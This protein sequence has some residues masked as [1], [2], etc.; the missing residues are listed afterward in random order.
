MPPSK[1]KILLLTPAPPFPPTNGGML[2]I[3]SL[4][5]ALKK[6]FN[7]SLLTFTHSSG[8]RK[9]TETAKLIALESL[10][11]E[12]HS[13]PLETR[14]SPPLCRKTKNLKSLKTARFLINLRSYWC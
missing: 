11:T 14:I 12:I 10:F 5:Q 6:D 7:F 3:V 2:R 1:P 13:I 4:L 8:E 9:F